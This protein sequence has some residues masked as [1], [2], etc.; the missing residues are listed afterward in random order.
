MEYGYEPGYNDL[1]IYDDK[2]RIRLINEILRFARTKGSNLHNIL[3]A[4]HNFELSY[5]FIAVDH[6]F[7]YRKE[8]TRKVLG[9]YDSVVCPS[10]RVIVFTA[11][12]DGLI[13]LAC[14]LSDKYMLLKNMEG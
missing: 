3:K 2:T 10:Y 11:T 8:I 13:H 4:E 12:Y 14:I 1:V 5:D 9:Y 7:S 6:L